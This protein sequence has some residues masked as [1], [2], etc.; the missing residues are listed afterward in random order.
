MSRRDAA[1]DSGLGRSLDRREPD[2]E[3]GAAVGPDDLPPVA[4]AEEEGDDDAGVGGQGAAPD[5]DEDVIDV[6]DETPEASDT[7]SSDS[8]S[9]DETNMAVQ[10]NQLSTIDG[11]N[12]GDGSKCRR[13]IGQVE[14]AKGL[15]GWNDANTAAIIPN[16]IEGPACLA[17]I[18]QPPTEKAAQTTKM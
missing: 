8:D 4:E 16:T 9:G 17:I 14:R 11:Y 12:G 1:R 6:G 2:P 5:L 15:F 13:F 3:E 10:G 18:W 7:D